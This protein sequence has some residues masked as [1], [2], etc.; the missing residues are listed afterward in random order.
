MLF[1]I[2][3]YFIFIKTFDCNNGIHIA[4]KYHIIFS[5]LIK[6]KKKIDDLFGIEIKFYFA[7]FK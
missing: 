2:F 7:A 4:V 3:P 6:C 5:S 1:V